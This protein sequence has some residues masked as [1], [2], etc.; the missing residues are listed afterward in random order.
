MAL[1]EAILRDDHRVPAPY[2]D[3]GSFDLSSASLWGRPRKFVVNNFPLSISGRPLSAP[4]VSRK[5]DS[6]KATFDEERGQTTTRVSEHRESQHRA[7]HE[8]ST[9][10]C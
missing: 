3:V 8:Y 5:G 10:F 9:S 2:V 7:C 1:G 4:Q 6:W